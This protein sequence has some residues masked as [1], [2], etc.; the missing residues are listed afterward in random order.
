[1]SAALTRPAAV[2]FDCDGVLAD[3]EALHDRIM[4]AEVSRLGWDISP[5][6]GARRFG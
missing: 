3:T 4:A 2:L 1:M 6:E 5:E